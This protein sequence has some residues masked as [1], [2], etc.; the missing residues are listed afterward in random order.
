M[1]MMEEIHQD[2][3]FCNVCKATKDRRD[4]FSPIGILSMSSL[5]F[6]SSLF[7]TAV[8]LMKAMP[9]ELQAGMGGLLF[10]GYLLKGLKVIAR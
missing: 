5:P 2:V 9:I 8:Y 4:R 6:L 7:A 10:T 1:N 3:F